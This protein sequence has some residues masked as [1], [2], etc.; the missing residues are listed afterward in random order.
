MM[1]SSTKNNDIDWGDYTYYA[2][3]TQDNVPSTSTASNRR[4]L[5]QFSAARYAEAQIKTMG[6]MMEGRRCR[7]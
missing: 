1:R 3:L 5:A 7:R 2:R 6:G 4:Y